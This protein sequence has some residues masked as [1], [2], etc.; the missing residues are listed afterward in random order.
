M[1][2]FSGP[3]GQLPAGYAA[4]P[5][6]PEQMG[7]I[8]RLCAVVRLDPPK[9]GLDAGPFV[10]LRE[11]LDAR[12][13]L[14]CLADTAGR[15][16]KWLEV[17]VQDPSGL[18]NA[19][20]AYRDA[21]N[22]AVLDER[23]RARVDSFETMMSAVG[24][25]AGS[26]TPATLVRTG[27]EASHPAPIFLDVKRKVPAF[28][29]DRASGAAWL[30]C[31]D[32]KLLMQKGAPAYRSSLS[33]HLFQPEAGEQTPLV[34]LDVVGA[35]PHALGMDE[36]CVAFNGG[37]GLMMVQAY[38]PMSYEQYVDAV[39]GV[40][41]GATGGSGASTGDS[42]SL[43]K[44]LALSAGVG[45]AGAARSLGWLNLRGVGLSGRLVEAL[46]LKLMLLAGAV[47]AVRAATTATQAPLLNLSANSFRV[48]MGDGHAALP[49]WWTAQPML[50][51][52][53]EGVELPLK[54][55]TAKYY[56]A[57]RGGGMTIYAPATLGRAAVG[58]GMLRLRDVQDVSDG[59][60]LEGTL[61][62][63]E[64]IYPGSNDLLWLRF[65]VGPMRL[66]LYGMVDAK[67]AL[68]AGEM[69][70]RTIPH[71]LSADVVAR[72]RT[73]LGVPIPEVSFEIIP[74]ISTPADLYALGVLA[75]RTLLVDGKRPLPVAMDE[76]LSLV[77]RAAAKAEEGS[78]L[79][80]R[81]AASFDEDPRFLDSLGPQRLLAESLEPARAFEAIPPRLWHSVLAMA[82]KMLTGIGP[83]ATCRDVGDAPV[84][85]VHRVF[86]A[87]S[88]DLYALLSSCRGL[89]VA[90]QALT[91]EVRG[92]VAG[93]LAA[94]KS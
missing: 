19:L 39:T 54:G 81:I 37:G 53:G 14:G 5:L 63:Q 92:V 12:V 71:A 74:L 35:D 23:W 22:N 47:T 87:C 59:V 10:V 41:A 31:E 48:R 4:V 67:A 16:Q 6:T 68:G 7:A 32:E 70:V 30:L 44:T 66:D 33:R 94:V 40:A 17:W 85:A 69:R 82:A 49:L 21:L 80:A 76:M 24:A 57:A 91:S 13:Y 64:R 15:V 84:G 3:P 45:T 28:C 93:C 38:C 62:T 46:H 83:D 55:T 50:V 73:A 20:P 34:P 72:L 43:R 86:D 8:V 27:W 79:P 1:S 78:D 2:V 36:G 25:Q 89:I 58:R 90:D 88:D 18:A 51:E 77:A 9:G 75:V 60:V 42:D 11:T 56:L 61:S 65:G 52:P 29:R 26:F